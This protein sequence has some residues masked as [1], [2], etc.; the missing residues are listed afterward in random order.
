MPFFNW[1]ELI[2]DVAPGKTL[3]AGMS[4]RGVIL[5]DS[6]LALHEAFPNLKCKPHTHV[7]SQITYM[8]KGKL[9]M[10]IGDEERV[11]LPGEFAFVPSNVEHSIESLDEYVLAVDVFQPY[12]KDIAERLEEL[13]AMSAPG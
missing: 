4:R 5:G 7:S 11:L 9:R 12:R 1:L 8:L 10:R 3:P 13:H 6:M 2:K